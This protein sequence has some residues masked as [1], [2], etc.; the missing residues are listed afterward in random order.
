MARPREFDETTALN[1]AIDCFWHRDRARRLLDLIEQATGKAVAGRDSAETCSAF[2]G[3]LM[4]TST[5][6][7]E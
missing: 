6:M 1:A 4:S 2:S 3:A 7:A 5:G